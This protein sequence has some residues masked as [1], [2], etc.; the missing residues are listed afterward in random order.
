MIQNDACI[1]IFISI[2]LVIAKD[3]KSSNYPLVDIK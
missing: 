2:L 1:K 3:Q